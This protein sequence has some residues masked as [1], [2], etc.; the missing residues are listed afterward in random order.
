MARESVPQAPRPPQ[1][2]PATVDSWETGRRSNQTPLLWAASNGHKAVV[3][4]LL[5]RTDVDPNHSDEFGPT[6]PWAAAFHGHKPVVELLLV[7]DGVNKNHKNFGGRTARLG[8]CT[9]ADLRLLPSEAVGFGAILLRDRLG[10]FLMP[11]VVA[12]LERVLTGRQLHSQSRLALNHPSSPPGLLQR[13]HPS[14]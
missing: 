9:A 11:C 8:V 5:A 3:Q 10:L 1:R 13:F 14:F 12:A 2:G 7:T 4:L 6:P